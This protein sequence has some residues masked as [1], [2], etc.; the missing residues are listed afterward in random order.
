MNLVALETTGLETACVAVRDLVE[1]GGGA[2][3]RV[4]LVGLAPQGKSKG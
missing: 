3:R 4:E 1:A 2:V